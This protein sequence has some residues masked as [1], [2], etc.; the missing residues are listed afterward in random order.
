LMQHHTY[1]E[2]EESTLLVKHQSGHQDT[3]QVPEAPFEADTRD[4]PIAHRQRAEPYYEVTS[5]DLIEYGSN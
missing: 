3:Q 1:Q 2:S 5:R 4:Q